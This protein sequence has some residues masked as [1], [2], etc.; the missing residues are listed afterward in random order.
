MNTKRVYAG[1]IDFVITCIIQII[2]MGIFI[3]RPLL[4][5]VENIISFN[6]MARQLIITYCSI[7]YLIIR[8]IFWKK[9]IGKK[10]FKLKII[11][12]NNGDEAS[13][14]KRILR[15]LSW[16][17]GPVDILV[18]IITRER[19]GDKIFGTNVIEE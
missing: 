9:S 4:G 7:L 2:L 16:V 10:I 15:N 1:L 11:D 6:I 12:R 13:I 5:A 19:L 14:I 3:F 17:L 8:D 18:F